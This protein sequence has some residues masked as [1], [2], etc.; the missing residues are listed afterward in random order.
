ME[1][2]TT[3]QVETLREYER[4]MSAEVVPAIVAALIRRQKL[5]AEARMREMKPSVK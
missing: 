1:P 3:I 5:A 4:A 2:L